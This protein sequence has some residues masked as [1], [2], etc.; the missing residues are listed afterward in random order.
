MNFLG[1]ATGF[2]SFFKAYKT[3]ERK[4]FL[5]NESLDNFDKMQNRELP[6]Y[7]ALYCKLC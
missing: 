3:S 2:D 1:G 6:P 5:P 4:R 7:D